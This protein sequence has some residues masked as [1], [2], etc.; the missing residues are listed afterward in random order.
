MGHKR[1]SG[2]SGK[3]SG[4]LQSHVH[5]GGAPQ[6]G[7]TGDRAGKRP[8]QRDH[9]MA[10]L[11][12]RP[13]HFLLREPLLLSLSADRCFFTFSSLL[14]LLCRFSYT[15]SFCLQWGTSVGSQHRSGASAVTQ[16]QQRP[17]PP[18]LT[19]EQTEASKAQRPSRCSYM[20]PE[21]PWGQR[22]HVLRQCVPST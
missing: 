19:G 2:T 11:R 8:E 5:P 15:S 12:R 22:L 16:R 18:H 9:T 17:E 14:F 20:R 7:D 1:K 3:G 4:A 6:P 13:A 21:T 10:T